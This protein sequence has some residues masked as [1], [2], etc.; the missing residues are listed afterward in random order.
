[1]SE[2][3][4]HLDDVVDTVAAVDKTNDSAAAQHPTAEESTVQEVMVQK[5]DSVASGSGQKFADADPA[6]SKKIDSAIAQEPIADSAATTA[7]TRSSDKAVAEAMVMLSQKAEEVQSTSQPQSSQQTTQS[8][9]SL[10]QQPTPIITSPL[11]RIPVKG[12]VIREP[13]AQQKKITS[14]SATDKGKGKMVEESK[15]MFKGI[16]Y[17]QLPFIYWPKE[18]QIEHDSAITRKEQE[19][20]DIEEQ[21]ILQQE[22]QRADKEAE[23]L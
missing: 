5:V 2:A 9:Q 6:A 3:F 22:K 23:D 12:V 4:K 14:S 8:S 15:F 21:Q 16:D 1:L 17:S 13:A 19:L 18:L 11:P 7:T 10:P 20:I